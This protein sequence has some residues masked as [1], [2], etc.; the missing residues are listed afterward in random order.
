MGG[1]MGGC[2]GVTLGGV[3]W[4]TFGGHMGGKSMLLLHSGCIAPFTHRQ[5]H[6]AFALVALTDTPTSAA[7]INNFRTVSFPIFCFYTALSDTMA[8]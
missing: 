7:N 1:I 8:V 3:I 4:Q 5:T 2:I 6:F